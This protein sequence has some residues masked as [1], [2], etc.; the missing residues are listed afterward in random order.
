MSGIVGYAALGAVVA[1][2]VWVHNAD[3]RMLRGISQ[4]IRI[5]KRR[6]D[7]TMSS[8]HVLSFCLS[9]AGKGTCCRSDL[10]R[11]RD[12][13]YAPSLNRRQAGYHHCP[14]VNFMLYNAHASEIESYKFLFHPG[15]HR[16]RYRYRLT[17][18]PNKLRHRNLEATQVSVS[19]P[20][21]YI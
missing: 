11:G 6:C 14:R 18:A 7:M 16:L 21:R 9:P 19:L 10:V 3:G 20:R 4:T 15:N 13:E 1:Q 12:T 8:L 17:L 5:S 2:S